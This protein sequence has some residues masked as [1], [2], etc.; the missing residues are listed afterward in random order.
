MFTGPRSKRE[1]HATTQPPCAPQPRPA[2][3]RGPIPVPGRPPYGTTYITAKRSSVEQDIYMS[4]RSV[5]RGQR[6]VSIV[7]DGQRTSMD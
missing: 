6:V 2:T 3:R 4:I 5:R 1:P 7:C